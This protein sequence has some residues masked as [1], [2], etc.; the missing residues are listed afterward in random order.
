MNIRLKRI[1][2]P[3]TVIATIEREYN[4]LFIR[5]PISGWWTLSSENPVQVLWALNQAYA[6]K[7]IRA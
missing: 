7:E 4:C 6:N 1:N 2:L 5:H 3:K